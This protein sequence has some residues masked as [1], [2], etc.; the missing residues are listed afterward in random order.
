[1]APYSI[2]TRADFESFLHFLNVDLP[3]IKILL[4]LPKHVFSAM[5]SYGKIQRSV[6]FYYC[7][8]PFFIAQPEKEKSIKVI[9]VIIPWQNETNGR[10]SK[11]TK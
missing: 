7:R 1:M 2:R 3:Q 8:G 9:T 10:S 4:P 5:V 11:I 6:S